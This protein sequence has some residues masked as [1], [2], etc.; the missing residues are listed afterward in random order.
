LSIEELQSLH[1]SGVIKSETLV[2]EEGNTE[3]RIFSSVWID[4]KRT[5]FCESTEKK[6]L[7]VVGGVLIA[8]I[9]ALFIVLALSS[10]FAANKAE[11][12]AI[13]GGGDQ[14]A[15]SVTKGRE[16]PPPPGVLFVAKANAILRKMDALSVDLANLADSG[17]LPNDL[18]KVRELNLK[19]TEIIDSIDALGIG[20]TSLDRENF[21]ARLILE[22][23]RITAN[24]LQSAALGVLRDDVDF[25]EN[26]RIARIGL[27]G[28]K[29]LIERSQK[30]VAEKIIP[31]EEIFDGASKISDARDRLTVQKRAADMGSWRA[32]LAY[33]NS[34]S[35]LEQWE[36]A[37]QYWEMAAAQGSLNA[38]NNLGFLYSGGVG[39][40]T[41]PPPDKLE[42]LK[43][44]RIGEIVSGEPSFN[45][46]TLVRT[47]SDLDISRAEIAA[48]TWRAAHSNVQ[49]ALDYPKEH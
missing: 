8:S 32:Q 1:R 34:L 25:R 22:R 2:F 39:G 16:T 27:R 35:I 18:Q 44:Y 23:M 49:E 12:S 48:A 3:W 17:T 33:G 21:W 26:L 30:P 47:V 14:L 42:A 20:L 45:Y 24:A 5:A 13:S 28:G 37:R 7:L 38:M 31:A 15:D 10:L 9:L 36:G 29:L 46:G 6:V 11:N 19:A 43:W 4:T 41:A 40:K